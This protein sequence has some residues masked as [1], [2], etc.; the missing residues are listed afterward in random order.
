MIAASVGFSAVVPI[1]VIPVPIVIAVLRSGRIIDRRIEGVG[2]NATLLNHAETVGVPGADRLAR[3]FIGGL[4]QT[5]GHR[6]PE[7]RVAGAAAQT[8]GR[9]PGDDRVPYPH[10]SPRSP[11]F[12]VA[13]FVQPLPGCK[14][15]ENDEIPDCA[16]VRP[17]GA[18]MQ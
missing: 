15:W 8:G 5:L 16:W 6:V 13:I 18:Y 1:P 4:I 10:A 12:P 17:P 2:R 9:Q 3:Q 11:S 14:R 7:G